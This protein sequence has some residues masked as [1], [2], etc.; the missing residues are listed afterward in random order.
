[1]LNLGMCGV[2]HPTLR[3]WVEEMTA[4]CQPDRVFW[5]DGSEAEKAALTAEAVRTG[6]LVELDQQKWPGCHHHRSHPSDVARSEH[7]T[8]I[9]TPTRD[10]AGPN[11]TLWQPAHGGHVGFPAGAFPGH[12]MA[13]PE[14]AID[15]LKRHL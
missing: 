1:M 10:E 11:V 6:V 12:V 13:L 3:A 9:C 5:C 4:L 15:W 2:D 7:L 8:F 14:R